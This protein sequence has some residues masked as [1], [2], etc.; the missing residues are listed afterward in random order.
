VGAK[1]NIGNQGGVGD[2][3]PGAKGPIGNTGFGF[4]GPPGPTGPVGTKGIK[5]NRGSTGAKGNKGLK[6][7]RG[8]QGGTGDKGPIGPAS[9]S[10]YAYEYSGCFPDS[11]DACASYDPGCPSVFWSDFATLKNG[12]NIFNNDTCTSQACPC[13]DGE[14]FVI[15]ATSEANQCSAGQITDQYNC[16]SDISLKTGVTTLRNSLENIMNMRPVEYDWNEISP[17]YQARLKT[18]KIHDIGFIAQDILVMYPPL[19][20]QDSE[21]YYRMS[22]QKMNAILVE[23]VK[24][25]Q[26]LIDNISEDIKYLSSIL[27]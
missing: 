12:T 23:G 18:N 11:N 5:G 22:Y 15:C 4:P 19:T 20:Y 8:T 2:N 3:N 16:T 14:W 1:G 27:K 24:E 13:T 17:D 6:G 10:C 26:A 9:A 7:N 25:Q 21:G